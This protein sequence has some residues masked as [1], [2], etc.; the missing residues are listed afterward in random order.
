MGK[1]NFF[2]FMD[3]DGVLASWE[4][5]LCSNKN[6]NGKNYDCINNRKIKAVDIICSRYPNINFYFI[7]VSSWSRVFKLKNNLKQYFEDNKIENLKIYDS[8]HWIDDRY[9]IPGFKTRHLRVANILQFLREENGL[10][11]ISNKN[12]MIFDDEQ[13]DVYS[14]FNLRHICSD[15][16][17]G[18]MQKHFDEFC[19]YLETYKEFNNEI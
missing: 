10:D 14:Y 7:P 18:L 2:L 16:Y 5:W 6:I 11:Y 8:H 4:D 3:F 9:E 12:Y 19:N 13:S 1:N 17:D 15:L